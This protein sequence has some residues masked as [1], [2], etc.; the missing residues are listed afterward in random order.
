MLL[1]TKVINHPLIKQLVG[2]A[3][4]GVIATLVHALVFNLCFTL[5]SFHHVW[6]NVAGFSV[7][8]SVSYFGQF[9]WVFKQQAAQVK[10]KKSTFLKF[11][12]TAL[13]G[14]AIN[15][16]WAYLIL[17][18]MQLHH[19]FYLALLTFVTP[20]VLFCLNKLWV[21]KVK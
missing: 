12:S 3:S 20:L 6:A 5:L 21:F 17:T 19:Y 2:F 13:T 18:V 16:L 15:L 4:V 10:S 14:F 9:Y 7:A 1:H 11:L 8:F